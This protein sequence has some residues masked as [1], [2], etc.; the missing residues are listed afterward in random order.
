MEQDDQLLQS[1]HVQHIV[2][3]TCM[4]TSESTQQCL[5]REVNNEASLCNART[6]DCYEHSKRTNRSAPPHCTATHT[7]TSEAPVPR[8]SDP[9]LCARRMQNATL[10][11]RLY[12]RTGTAAENW[13]L[14]DG[15]LALSS[16]LAAF[17]APEAKTCQEICTSREIKLTN[18]RPPPCAMR[19]WGQTMETFVV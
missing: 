11:H 7:P 3:H 18:H 8:V 9:R 17:C 2:L 16:S 14:C 15:I 13:M 19:S 5:F 1:K 12:T 6:L 10:V 4:A